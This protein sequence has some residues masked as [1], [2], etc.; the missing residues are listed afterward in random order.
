MREYIKMIVFIFIVG[1][2]AA[3]TLIGVDALTKTRIEANKLVKFQGAILN[4]NG[5]EFNMNNIG[6]IYDEVIVETP[7][8]VTVDGKIQNLVTYEHKDTKNVSFTFR[9]SGLWGDIYGLITLENDF[10]T[11][12]NIVVLEQEET[13]GLGAIVGE[14]SFL[15]RFIGKMFDPDIKIVAEANPDAN[16]EIDRI[17]GA[18]G[19]STA[20]QKI[21]NDTHSLYYMVYRGGGVLT[22]DEMILKAILD[23]YAFDFTNDSRKIAEIFNTLFKTHTSGDL[24][25]YEHLASGNLSFSFETTNGVDAGGNEGKGSPIKGIVTLLADFETIEKIFIYEESEVFGKKL[26]TRETLDKLNGK[27]ITEK[28]FTVKDDQGIID[29]TSGVTYTANIINIGISGAYNKNKEFGKTLELTYSN[30]FRS[31]ILTHYEINF[32]E[33]LSDILTI[34]SL[35]FNVIGNEEG[36]VVTKKGD[37]TNTYIYFS[38][39]TFGRNG[40]VKENILT[41]ITL[42]ADNKTVLKIKTIYPENNDHWGKRDFLKQEVL[43]RAIG[44]D[45]NDVQ[46]KNMDNPEDTGTIDG[47]S[48]V[49]LTT[50]DFN[51]DL[52][53]YYG[54]FKSLVKGDN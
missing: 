28:L 9:G 45:M 52:K 2:I 51:R 33:D 53:L 25:I 16:N 4:A 41:I 5:T 20:F 13:P 11:I 1:V 23:S 7:E 24:N 21:L 15:D 14:K 27:K 49:T 10:N 54:L 26:L 35:N 43:D 18:T 19:T 12:V 38:N 48:R 3:G 31:E 22:E 32:N 8:E 46:F 30:E 47:E 17:T 39:L 50:N 29:S 37:T 6:E 44:K 40:P 34:F 42:E 36:Y